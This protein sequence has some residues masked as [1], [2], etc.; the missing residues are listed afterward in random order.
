MEHLFAER[1][2]ES[3]GFLFWGDHWLLRSVVS[4]LATG[5][6]GT[7]AGLATPKRADLAGLLS[8]IPTSVAW[9][10]GAAGLWFAKPEQVYLPGRT[11]WWIACGALTIVSPL[12][13]RGCGVI[14]GQVRSDNASLFSRPHRLLGIRW[15]HWLWI[16]VPLYYLA[17]E[18]FFSAVLTI[19]IEL[20]GSG[21]LSDVARLATGSAAF[22]MLLGAWKG[23][24][25][26]V[27]EGQP[28]QQGQRKFWGVLLYFLVLPGTALLVRT[29]VLYA[30]GKLSPQFVPHI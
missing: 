3:W 20:A 14:G 17:S 6:G 27:S 25:L 21:L 30:V 24:A 23:V 15:F 10:L 1:D 9:L 22:V 7:A 26:L 11:G 29:G 16:W 13:A 5:A 28:D 12:V 19:R 18:F 2:T 8:G 4:L